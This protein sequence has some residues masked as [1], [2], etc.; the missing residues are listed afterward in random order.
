MNK[1][2]LELFLRYEFA[3]SQSVKNES[4]FWCQDFKF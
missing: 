1:M 4:E 2:S 3:F